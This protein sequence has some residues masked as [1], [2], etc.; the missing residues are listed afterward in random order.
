LKGAKDLLLQVKK[1]GN[2][3]LSHCE[4][5][6]D[7]DERKIPLFAISPRRKR[8]EKTVPFVCTFRRRKGRK[9][10]WEKKRRRPQRHTRPDE[11]GKKKKG[12]EARGSCCIDLPW[13]RRR[14][15]RAFP[16]E[17]GKATA[18][19]L[20]SISRKG[21]GKGPLP[22]LIYS[23]GGRK[24]LK[25]REAQ[26]AQLDLFSRHGRGRGKGTGKSVGVQGGLGLSLFR[27]KEG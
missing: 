27:R 17:T 25:K 13:G 24:T 9:G 19:P 10:P 8:E 23:H 20:F 18:L 21:K 6:G 3:L 2:R 12:D 22:V 14:E 15:A 16:K 4:G 7:S 5:E 26:V 11:E 1:E